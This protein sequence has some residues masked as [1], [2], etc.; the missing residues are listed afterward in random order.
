MPRHNETLYV[1]VDGTLLIWP[2]PDPSR[3]PPAPLIPYDR[4]EIDHEVVRALRRWKAANPDGQLIVWSM[5]GR[6]HAE[7]AVGVCDLA[8]VVD[9]VLAKPGTMIDDAP[10]LVWFRD[11]RLLAPGQAREL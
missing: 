2:Q 10:W 11:M 6:K 4:A 3:P 8:D 7:R 5:R 9:L 1:D